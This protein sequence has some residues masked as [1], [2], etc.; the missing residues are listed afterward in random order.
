MEGK[1][2]SYYPI[3]LPNWLPYVE[4]NFSF[5][6]IGTSGVAHGWRNLN[7]SSPFTCCRPLTGILWN[8]KKREKVSLR[9]HLEKLH[10]FH[11]NTFVL[12]RSIAP[13]NCH[14]PSKSTAQARSPPSISK[15]HHHDEVRRPCEDHRACEVPRPC[16]VSRPCAVHRF[17]GLLRKSTAPKHEKVTSLCCCVYGKCLGFSSERGFLTSQC[18]P[19]AGYSSIWFKV[20]FFWFPQIIDVVV[21]SFWCG[22]E[23]CMSNNCGFDKKMSL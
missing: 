13:L 17:G 10:G 9:R 12:H 20:W 11:T 5:F 4:L 7:L 1:C 3:W 18:S 15:I 21:V 14:T 2:Y 23:K 8:W 22:L 16:E 19:F 6:L